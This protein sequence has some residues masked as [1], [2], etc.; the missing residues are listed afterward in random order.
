MFLH[1]HVKVVDQSY[2]HSR[3]VFSIMSL[4]QSREGERLL[5]SLCVC[6]WLFE[7]LLSACQGV[8]LWRRLAV[9]LHNASYV[10]VARRSRVKPSPSYLPSRVTGRGNFQLIHDF[11]PAIQT[12][13]NVNSPTQVTPLAFYKIFL[14]SK[15]LRN[16]SKLFLLPRGMTETRMMDS[17]VLINI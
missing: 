12:Q 17:L 2:C 9:K 1:L 3:S 15:V 13:H 11:P 6:V 16:I 14:D 7:R 8:W 4:C 10:K 5:S